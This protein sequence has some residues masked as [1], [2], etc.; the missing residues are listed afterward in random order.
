MRQPFNTTSN[1]TIKIYEEEQAE[2]AGEKNQ[3]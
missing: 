2:K 1:T 3:F